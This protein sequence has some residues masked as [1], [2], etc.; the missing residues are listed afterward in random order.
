MLNNIAIAP[1][2][3]T[4]DP[5]EY[6]AQMDRIAGF[7]DGVHIDFADG[8]FAPSKM[9]PIDQA[10]RTDDLITHAHVMYQRPMEFIDDIIHLEADLVILHAESD[11]LKEC[12]EMLNNIGVRTGVAI[13]PE[14]SVADLKDLDIDDLFDHILVFGG[15]LGYQGGTADL[16]IL[17]KVEQVR[18]EYPDVEIGWD[19]G[20]NAENAAQIV[21]A[22]VTV[23]NVGGYF[24][25]AEDPKKAYATM[26]SL[27]K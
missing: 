10:W 24:K 19:G 5:D 9:L 25:K 4:D 1:T 23:L 26:K 21:K 8:E 14:T 7:A 11:D 2:I 20:I 12:L 22:G 13:L 15:H 17:K 27:L 16:S 6:R 3:T 18:H